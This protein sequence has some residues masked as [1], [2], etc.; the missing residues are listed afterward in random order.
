MADS[1]I[2]DHLDSEEKLEEENE[3][4]DNPHIALEIGEEGDNTSHF[5]SKQMSIF[6]VKK[7]IKVTDIS[8]NKSPKN[9]T[10]KKNKRPKN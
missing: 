2:E 4:I 8:S 7:N 1:D 6:T 10:R 3:K 5:K 9:I